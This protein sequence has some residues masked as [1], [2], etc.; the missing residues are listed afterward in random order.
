VSHSSTS[1]AEF[2]AENLLCPLSQI[3]LG[4]KRSEEG[5]VPSRPAMFCDPAADQLQGW[6]ELILGKLIDELM[7]FLA[8]RAHTSIL[9]LQTSVL[10]A[11]AGRIP[12]ALARAAESSRQQ[13]P[14]PARPGNANCSTRH[15]PPGTVGLMTEYGAHIAADPKSQSKSQRPQTPSHARPRPATIAAA[16][17]H[18]RP[19]P[20]PS[21]HATDF[22]YKRGVRRFK[23]YCAHLF[24]MSVGVSWR[25]SRIRT[26]HRY[27]LPV[28]TKNCAVHGCRERKPRVLAPEATAAT[29]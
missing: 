10:M 18:V 20:T 2:G 1:A 19:F 8:H 3:R 5:Q 15:V 22:A 11:T 23:S 24:R 13:G 7:E 14:S 26:S 6:L 12:L 28:W 21:R 27:I 29:A 25:K 17:C 16:R 4:L 9:R